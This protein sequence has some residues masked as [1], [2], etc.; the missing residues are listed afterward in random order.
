[1]ATLSRFLSLHEI[2]NAVG[3][4]LNNCDNINITIESIC[5]DSR[6]D[7]KNG[8]F[9]PIVGDRVDG[10]DYIEYA[11]KAGAGCVLSEQYKK[12]LTNPF[13]KVFS[14]R[15]AFGMLARYYLSLF[16][17]KIVAITGSSGKTTTKDFLADILSK[18]YKIHKTKGN[19][20]NDIGL[21]LTI[22]DIHKDIEVLILE[23]GM[24]HFGEL[25]RLSYITR[26]NIAVITNIGYAHIENLGDRDGIL[27]AK[28]EIFDYMDEN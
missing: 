6:L 23:M 11:Y 17:V 20:N 10:H 1:M 16:D 24:N 15:Y 14:C 25:S 13:I 2:A 28:T 8:L 12:D 21:P 4:E 26:P 3:G 9:I 18:K 7:N 19:F 22:F 5:I 27:K